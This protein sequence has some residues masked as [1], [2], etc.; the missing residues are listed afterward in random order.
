MACWVCFQ[1]LIPLWTV[2]IALLAWWIALPT[3]NIQQNGEGTQ[4]LPIQQETILLD[5]GE[6]ETGMSLTLVPAPNFAEISLSSDRKQSFINWLMPLILHEN[7]Q[8]AT[9]RKTA[10]RLYD[11]WQKRRLSLKQKEWLVSVATDYN[12][13]IDHQGFNL[14]F[15]QNLLHRLDVV[16]PSLVITQ[17]AIETGWGT[18]RVAKDANNF[19]GMMCFTPGCGM[20]IQGIQGEFRRYESPQASVASYM[21][22]LNISGAYRAARMERMKNRLLGEDPSG[23]KMAR[24]LLAYSELGSR[25]VSFLIRI[26]QDNQLDMLDGMGEVDPAM[27]NKG[28]SSE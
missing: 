12:V 15:W 20:A 16:P 14:T 7:I 22:L 11:A 3:A 10:V 18:S 6:E 27:L 21:R 2:A 25:Y 17:A 13:T 9:D 23:E 19:F 1:R 26:M 24:T 28:E 8:I 5:E 4:D